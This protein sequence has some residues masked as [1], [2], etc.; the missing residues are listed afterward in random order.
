MTR[1]QVEAPQEF[2]YGIVT[3]PTHALVVPQHIIAPGRRSSMTED[4][5]IVQEP[6]TTKR[7]TAAH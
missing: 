5:F 2:F 4:Y 3:V 6:F 1:T 7:Q